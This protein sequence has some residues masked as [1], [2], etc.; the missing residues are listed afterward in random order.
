MEDLSNFEVPSLIR[1]SYAKESLSPTLLLVAHAE[2]IFESELHNPRIL[3]RCHLPEN[4]T[5]EVGCRVLHTKS[6]SNVERLG[7]EFQFLSLAELE[8]S[9]DSHIELPVAR[10][11]NTACATVPITT[12]RR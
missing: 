9:G 11:A 1:L 8:C 10:T 12:Q 7:S 6:V 2:H 5:A 3:R 4:T